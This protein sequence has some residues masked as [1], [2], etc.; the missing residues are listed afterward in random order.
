MATHSFNVR[1]RPRMYIAVFIATGLTALLI[2]GFIALTDDI[3]TYADARL[4]SATQN[5]IQSEFAQVAR[6]R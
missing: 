5:A 1:S 3:R 2:E 4:T 6:R